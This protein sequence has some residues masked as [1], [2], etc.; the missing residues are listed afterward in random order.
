MAIDDVA[1]RR[2]MLLP[3]DRETAWAALADPEGLATWL[4]DEV[5][6]EIEAG[7]EGWLRWGDG[8]P[9]RATVEEVAERRRIVLRWSEAD[10]PETLVEL[11]LDDV[12]EGT[13]LVV[14]ELP[15]AQ[16]VAVGTLLERGTRV[17]GDSRLGTRRGPQM[18]ATLA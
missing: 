11:T 14:L 5:D 13:R 9:R 2:E 3:V 17:I 7:A 10:G 16:L 18:V 4:A 15:V 1:V 6:L 8:E 12:P